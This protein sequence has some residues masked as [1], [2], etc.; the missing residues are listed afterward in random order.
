MTK[1]YMDIKSSQMRTKSTTIKKYLMTY[2]TND[3]YSE[4]IHDM[5]TKPYPSENT[6]INFFQE[7]RSIKNDLK[8]Q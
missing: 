7:T 1:Q 2:Q 8:T 4:S 5:F 3:H 6:E